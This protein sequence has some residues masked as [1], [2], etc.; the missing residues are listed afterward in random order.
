MVEAA[1]TLLLAAGLDVAVVAD[2]CC[3]Q[4]ARD[5]GD[6]A[7][8]DD[9]AEH[10]GQQLAGAA[11]VVALDPHCAPSL[12]DGVPV[13]DLWSVLDESEL[14]W[15]D[16][17]PAREVTYHDPCLLARRDGVTDPPRRLLAAAGVRVVDPEFSGRDTA[18]SGAGMGLPLLDADAADATA[19]RRVAQLAATDAA[20]T[21]ACSRA[22]DRLRSAGRPTDD[23]AV[24]LASRVR[25]AP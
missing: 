13:R 6:A 19:R 23:L 16:D 18:C 25:T 4:L 22:A 9:R 11:Q 8:A 1:R 10:R 2:G 7:T 21:T 15:R 5:L 20:T 17:A 12:P 3:G 24:L 14:A